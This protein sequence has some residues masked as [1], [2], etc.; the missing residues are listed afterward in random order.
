V[1]GDLLLRVRAAVAAR[2]L[3]LYE[4]A[5]ALG[6]PRDDEVID[7]LARVVKHAPYVFDR[8]AGPDGTSSVGLRSHPTPD[9][10][11]AAAAVMRQA[12]RVG[13][14]VRADG[15]HL[16]VRPAPPSALRAALLAHKPVLLLLLR[17]LQDMRH[18]ARVAPRPALYACAWS[19]AGPGW[20]FSCGDPLE[21]PGA[22]GRCDACAVAADL[23]Y[24]DAGEQ[25]DEDDT[26][27]A[28]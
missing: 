7:E 20:C 24:A 19:K 15:S 10:L 5:D 14:T 13:L 12:H 3:K 18:F 26:S 9:A 17:R 1:T 23:F 11:C 8:Y 21:H 22:Y 6:L 28:A 2:P 25:S 16:C 4:I 27:G